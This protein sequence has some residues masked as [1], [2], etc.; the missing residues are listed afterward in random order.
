MNPLRPCRLAVTTW[1]GL[2]VIAA[3]LAACA[4]PDVETV[5]PV[6]ATAAPAARA[7][8]EPDPRSLGKGTAPVAL[9]EYSDYQCPYCQ[10]FHAAV[11]PRLKRDYID[12]GKL[13]LFFRDLPLPMHPQA[14]PA[15]V[16][17]RCAAQQGKFWP[18]NEALF[19]Q[20]SALA[21]ALYPRLAEALGLDG[22]RFRQCRDD[23]ET[24]QRVRRDVRD[25]DGYELSAT[26]TFLLGR[27][28]GTRIEIR[29]V[30][31]GYADFDTFAR[32]IDGLLA[33]SD[34]KN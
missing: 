33:T 22:A 7:P 12:T 13:I 20:Q 27:Y 16:A 17:A 3:G 14:L 26:P 5:S 4:T 34:K 1:F 6:G 18:M 21:P 32:A 29:N 10:Q 30:A 2:I 11:L 19:A 8:A 15:A 9:V 24:A 23:P 28:D 25:V 31:R